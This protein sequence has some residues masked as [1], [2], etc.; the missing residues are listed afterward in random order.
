MYQFCMD[1]R[2]Y[3]S[4]DLAIGSYSQISWIGSYSQI[5]VMYHFVVKLQ[6]SSL[7]MDLVTTKVCG[8]A[9]E[10]ISVWVIRWFST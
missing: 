4:H 9:S 7:Y 6:Y 10:R 5:S 1:I 8:H 2:I 3:V